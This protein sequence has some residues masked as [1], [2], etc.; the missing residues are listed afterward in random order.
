MRVERQNLIESLRRGEFDL[1]VIGGGITGAGIALDATLRG[2][3][4]ALVEKGDF[5]SG[6]SSASSKLIHGGLRYLEH[7]E[8]GLVREALRERHVLLRIAPHLVRPLK[9]VV[10]QYERAGRSRWTMKLGLSLYDW[11][12]GRER[13]GRHRWLAAADV[14]AAAPGLRE[15][16]LRGGFEF[17]D[18]QMD[19]ARLCLEVALTAIERG[20]RAANY[21]EVV[22]IRH[23][24]AGRVCGCEVSDR[25]TG[26]SFAIRARRVVNAAGPW[27]DEINRID[28]PTA[29]ERLAP[30]KGVHV[31]LPSLGLATGLLVTHP[32]DRRVM[33]MLPWMSRTLVGTTDT[34]Y[35][36]RTNDVVADAVDVEYL[37]AATNHYFDRGFAPHDVIATL[38]GLRPLLRRRSRDASAVSREFSI[39]RSASGLWSIAGGKYTTY[40]SMA[41]QLVDRVI[42]DFGESAAR[43]SCRTAD[44]RLVGCPDRNWATFR[45]QETQSLAAMY[46]MNPQITQQLVDRYGCRAGA[47]LGETGSDEQSRQPIIR[48]ELDIQAELP[49]HAHHEMAVCVADSLLRRTRLGLLHPELSAAD[50]KWPVAGNCGTLKP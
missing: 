40:R 6:T 18:A 49:Y 45:D 4:V 2:L 19:D 24:R 10:P 27:L 25:V 37:L 23:D 35:D 48:G 46:C 34:F 1:L 29:A 44:H 5:A 31:I 38:A 9:I 3:R 42:S 12:A 41:E 15:N 22:E 13:I 47:L 39:Y 33:F 43:S 36:D 8:F 20:A 30:T 7:G 32:A 16:G 26:E 28:D 11:L 14:V 50:L 17:F 21:V